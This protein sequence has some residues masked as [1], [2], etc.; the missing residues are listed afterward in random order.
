MLESM[1]PYSV[2]FSLCLILAAMFLVWSF[3]AFA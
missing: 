2:Y 1:F 3:D